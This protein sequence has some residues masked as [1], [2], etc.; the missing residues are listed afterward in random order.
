M[1]EEPISVAVYLRVSSD[2]QRN[3]ETIKTQREAIDRFLVHNPQCAVYRY[4]ED[5]GVSGTI[6][7]V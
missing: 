2:D 6:P 3:R 1:T 4:Y 5:D 7:P